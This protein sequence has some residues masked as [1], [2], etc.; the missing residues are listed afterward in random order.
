M[1]RAPPILAF[2]GVNS[3]S[4]WAND[5]AGP[6]WDKY[7]AGT[8]YQCAAVTISAFSLFNAALNVTAA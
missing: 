8:P 5:R 1:S 3:D 6:W 7:V 2:L 4:S